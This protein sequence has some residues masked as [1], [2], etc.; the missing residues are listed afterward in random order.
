M[1][2]SDCG[3]AVAGDDYYPLDNE[4]VIFPATITTKTVFI[5]ILPDDG[6]EDAV[7]ETFCVTLDKD[8]SNRGEITPISSITVTI[9]N[10]DSMCD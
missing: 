10:D 1:D 9:A 5:H 2:T 4:E 7:N 6:N 8:V 3:D